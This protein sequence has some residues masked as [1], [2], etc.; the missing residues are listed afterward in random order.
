ME[1]YLTENHIAQLWGKMARVYGHRWVSGFG[2][3]DDGTWL[4][5]LKGLVPENLAD[6]YREMIDSREYD[7]PPTL[8]EFRRLC[9]GIDDDQARVEAKLQIRKKIGSFDFNKLTV[10]Q[11][12][13]RIN[14]LLPSVIRDREY[15][16]IKR[17]E[18]AQA[19]RQAIME[20]PDMLQDLA[21]GKI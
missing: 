18:E 11:L 21:D 13:G 5:G 4:D 10:N 6:G 14:K 9:F 1:N 16:I 3:S 12:E 17:N 7:W 8:P 2:E 19:E 15:S 20:E